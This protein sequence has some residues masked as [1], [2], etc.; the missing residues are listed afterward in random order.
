VGQ[1]RHERG[2]YCHLEGWLLHPRSPRPGHHLERTDFVRG[3]VLGYLDTGAV[4]VKLTGR[5][6]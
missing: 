6:S 3:P 2:T 4:G 5:D 1:N